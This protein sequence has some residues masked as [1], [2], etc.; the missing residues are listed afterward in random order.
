LSVRKVFSFYATGMTINV[1]I[2]RM[3]FEERESFISLVEEAKDKR[4]NS[5]RHQQKT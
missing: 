4:Y 1:Q 5:R 2:N 3:P